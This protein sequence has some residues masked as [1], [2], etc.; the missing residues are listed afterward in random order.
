MKKNKIQKIL[1]FGKGQLGQE[2]ENLLKT[3][4]KVKIIDRRQVDIT[5]GEAVM[6]I[7]RRYSPQC[8]INAAAYTQVDKAEREVESVFKV[9][10]FGPHFLALAAKEVDA[11]FFHISSDYVFDGSK[12]FFVETDCPNPLNVYG[13]SKLSGEALVKFVNPKHYIIRTSAM[14]GEYLGEKRIN[15][16]DRMIELAKKGKP[17][18]VVKDQFTAPTFAFDLSGKI[19]EFIQKQ[20]PFGIYHITNKGSCS[21][22]EFAVKIMQLMNLRAKVRPIVTRNIPGQMIRPRYSILRNQLLKKYGLGELP[23]WEN[24][25]KRYCAVKYG[26]NK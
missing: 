3:K 21:W 11:I 22:Y 14:F 20:P 26:L 2:L 9:N 5:D 10:A 24:A 15:F 13:T 17:L 4:Y 19:M 7:T 6:K 18:S 12:K 25:L 8:V 1:I 16:V 23:R